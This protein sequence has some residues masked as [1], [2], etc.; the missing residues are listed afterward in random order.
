MEHFEHTESEKSEQNVWL[1]NQTNIY[2]N[3]LPKRARG[4][5]WGGRQEWGSGW[6]T[7]VQPWQIHVDV[8]QNQY[9]KIKKKFL[10]IC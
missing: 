5:V 3:I 6:G 7:R 4:M 9:C 10:I 2:Q 1:T 8:Q